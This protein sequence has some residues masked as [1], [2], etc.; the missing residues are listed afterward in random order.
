MLMKNFLLASTVLAVTSFAAAAADLPS[1]AA[2]TSRAPVFAQATSWQGFYVGAQLGLGNLTTTNSDLNNWYYGVRDVQTRDP[3]ALFGLR[4]GYDAVFGS[5]LAGG[6]VE[7]SFGS[8]DSQKEYDPAN[9][10]YRVGSNVKLLGSAR[11][12]LG[13]HSGD[14]SVFVTG[15]LAVSNHQYRYNETDGSG[16]T[17]RANAKTGYVFGVGAAYALTSNMSVGLDVSRYQFGEKTG[18][19]LNPNGTGTGAFWSVKSHVDTA[20]LSLN[21]RF[22]SAGSV[23][24]R[25]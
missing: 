23:V 4:A 10:A 15:G 5:L 11:A 25:Y 16:Q 8:L 6:L 14:L 24:A 18:Q 7:G 19:L 3:G 22:G 21:Y 20:M 9:P 17:M 13:V 1:R 12:K 2:A